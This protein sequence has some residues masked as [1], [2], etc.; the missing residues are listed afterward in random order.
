MQ[1]SQHQVSHKCDFVRHHLIA[2]LTALIFFEYLITMDREMELFWNR[3]LSY[4]TALF[5][6]NRYLIVAFSALVLTPNFNTVTW[7]NR[8]SQHVH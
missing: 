2:V 5:F 3:K 7:K 1:E 8:V 4:S 6:V